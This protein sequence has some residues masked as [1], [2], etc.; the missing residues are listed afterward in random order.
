MEKFAGLYIYINV[1]FSY[2]AAVVGQWPYARMDKIMK[3]KKKKK[4]FQPRIFRSLEQY[5]DMLS[6]TARQHGVCLENENAFYQH[7]MQGNCCL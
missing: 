5:G 3:K 1:L 4:K 2:P 7:S 6:T